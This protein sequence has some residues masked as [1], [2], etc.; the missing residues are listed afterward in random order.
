MTGV[1]IGSVMNRNRC[2]GPAPSMSAASYSCLGTSRSDARKMIIVL[3]MPHRPSRTRPGLENVGSW[4]HSG[5]G[6]WRKPR[7]WSIG[8]AGFSRNTNPR[9]AAT[10]G[11]IVGRKKIVR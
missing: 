3:P 7:M 8:P 2:N 1:I 6:T 4:N 11:T 5:F 10:T 9:A